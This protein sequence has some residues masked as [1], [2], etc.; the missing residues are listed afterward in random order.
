MMHS[1]SHAFRTLLATVAL[2]VV[3]PRSGS[4]CPPFENGGETV[5]ELENDSLDEASGL[6]ASRRHDGRF[7]THNDSGGEARVFLLEPSGGDAGVLDL[8]G[9]EATDWEDIAVGPCEPKGDRSC[10]Y[11]ADVGDNK[12]R[13]ESVSITRVPEPALPDGES[14]GWSTDEA[15]TV[16]FTYPDGPR[17]AETLLVHPETAEAYV[18]E[19]TPRAKATVYRVPRNSKSEEDDETGVEA[20][21]VSELEVDRSPVGGLITGGDVAPAGEAFTVRTYVKVFTFCAGDGEPFESSFEGD[22][23]VSH[24]RFTFQSEALAYGPDGESIWFTSEGKGAAVVRM[25]RD[26]SD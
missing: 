3:A 7:W 9:V 5:G 26:G 18:I 12:R 15:T 21:A 4:T 17:N 25:D 10:I 14:D 19:K 20:E 2:L 24:P 8:E 6:A 22:P 1:P 23:V 13:R 16:E 11:V